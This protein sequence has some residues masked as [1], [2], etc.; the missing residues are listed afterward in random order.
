M[1]KRLIVFVFALTIICQAEAQ[2][3]RVTGRHTPSIAVKSNLLYDATT[4]MNLGM[5]FKVGERLTLEASA[6]Y[7][8]WTPSEERRLRHILVQPELRWWFCEP[9]HGHFLGAHAHYAMFNVGGIS[10]PKIGIGGVGDSDTKDYRYEGWLAGAGI[11]YGYQFYLGRRWSLET[12]L[13]AGYAYLDYD[14]Y[15]C[16]KCG[17]FENSNTKHYFG[18]TKAGISLIYLIK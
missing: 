7:N 11:S 12:T 3:M 10:L 18:L 1:Y 5:E 15:Q 16:G 13:G 2:E 9:F 8:P 14:R 17:S 4:S 6:T